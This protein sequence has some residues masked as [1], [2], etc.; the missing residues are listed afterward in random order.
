MLGL[1]GAKQIQDAFKS[2]PA[3]HVGSI[4]TLEVF[5]KGSGLTSSKKTCR[6]ST[7]HDT[8]RNPGEYLGY[9]DGATFILA[10]E[11]L[12]ASGYGSPQVFSSFSG[13][14][15]THSPPSNANGLITDADCTQRT[16]DLRSP[17]PR[18]RG[19][20]QVAQ[21]RWQREACELVHRRGQRDRVQQGQQGLGGVQQR[22]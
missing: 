17:R 21:L 8:D 10:N 15:A 13:R 14:R 7:N 12:L 6:S 2:Y 11:W 18:H 1:D 16:M 4:A 3:E 9:K 20:G 22:H 5:G 19:D